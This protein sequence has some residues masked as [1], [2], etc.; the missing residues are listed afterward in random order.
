[1]DNKV[2]EHCFHLS[3]AIILLHDP[4]GMI[5]LHDS[6]T[7]L[8]SFYISRLQCLLWFTISHHRQGTITCSFTGS[9]YKTLQLS[10]LTTC[11]TFPQVKTRLLHP[12]KFHV[13]ENQKRQIQLYL[14]HEMGK[15][16]PTTAVVQSLPTLPRKATYL[17][18]QPTGSAPADPDSPMSAG[19]SSR[20]TSLSEVTCNVIVIITFVL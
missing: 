10:M 16:A 20:T 18:P 7:V 5:I 19:M 9:T 13:K 3:C 4:L 17:Q 15:S 14:N 11:L 8:A 1:M 6:I 2:L 12:T